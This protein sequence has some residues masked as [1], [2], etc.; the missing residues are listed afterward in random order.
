M[1]CLVRSS[2]NQIKI[3]GFSFT[4]QDKIELNKIIKQME[5]E[6]EALAEDKRE[7]EQEKSTIRNELV[8][9]EQDK[10]DLDAERASSDQK[11]SI[12]EQSKEKI[13]Q[14]LIV[15]NRERAELN[16]ALSKAL[17]EKPIISDDLN[18]TR[19]ELERQSNIVCELILAT[20]TYQWFCYICFACNLIR[21]F[22]FCLI[23]HIVIVRLSKEKEEL[24]R[25]RSSLTVQVSSGERENRVLAENIASLK[26]DKESLETALYETQ[27]N[28][29]KIELRKEAL[30][31]ENQEI[32]L[33]KEAIAVDL[34]RVKKEQEI[35]LS[36]MK[37]EQEIAEQKLG[38]THNEYA[39]HLK[40]VS[41]YPYF[42]EVSNDG[43]YVSNRE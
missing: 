36:K 40:K 1:Y 24:T 10:I 20:K 11:L 3:F 31:V 4:G 14:E 29:A 28:L 22:S 16:E 13:E 12:A 26:S 30:E 9:A 2:L 5:V 43:I 41:V 7:L 38:S 19:R 34:C 42:F 25:E 35:E 39:L 32:N 15:A 6:R 37:R 33:A 18:Q 8:K 23:F 27:Q 21:F 17:R